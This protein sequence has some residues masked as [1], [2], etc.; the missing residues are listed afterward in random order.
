MDELNGLVSRAIEEKYTDSPA[1]T[2]FSELVRKYQ[3]MVFG[4]VYAI[5]QDR[6]R[7]SGVCGNWSIM[8]NACRSW[9]RLSRGSGASFPLR[10]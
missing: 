5:V 4:L 2:A 8:S 7:L 1:R 9:P 10:L 3:D 6:R